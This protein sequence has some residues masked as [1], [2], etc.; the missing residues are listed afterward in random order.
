MGTKSSSL[1]RPLHANIGDHK[2][3][4]KD[5]LE[6]KMQS[7]EDEFDKAEPEPEPAF[8]DTHMELPQ[9]N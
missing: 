2:Y 9:S 5:M 7:L 3:P 8:L 1:Q 6:S 4:P